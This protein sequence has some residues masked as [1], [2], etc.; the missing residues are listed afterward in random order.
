[1]GSSPDDEDVER[2]DTDYVDPL[3]TS[4]DEIEADLKAEGIEGNANKAFADRI[5][6]ADDVVGAVDTG[7]DRIVTREDVENTVGRITDPHAEG[8]EPALVDAASK[9]L[10]A[11]SRSELNRA[12]GAVARQ[13][14]EDGIVRSNP[15]LDPLGGENGREIGTVAEV[16]RN[17][18]GRGGGLREGVEATGDGRGTFYY[19]D[20]GGNR[21]PMAE[22][23]L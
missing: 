14:D 8:R 12:R 21:Y 20:S 9:E 23:D 13:V 2:V 15:A 3:S 11:P 1:M 5:L 6:E 22:V 4:R 16:T 18:G 19:E 17:T 7:R 10:G